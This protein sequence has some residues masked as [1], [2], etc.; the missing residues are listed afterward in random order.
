[1]KSFSLNPC[2]VLGATIIV[3][4]I[5]VQ[6]INKFCKVKE[7]LHNKRFPSGIVNTVRKPE[8]KIFAHRH[9]MSSYIST[10]KKPPKNT[11]K[12]TKKPKKPTNKRTKKPPKRQKGPTLATKMT[13]IFSLLFPK[14]CGIFRA[15]SY[16]RIS[17]AMKSI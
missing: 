4:V 13:V 8:G 6:E 12:Q 15:S 10:L 5:S 17:Q 7:K 1:M 2:L 11:S 9:E 14:D 16:E 3:V